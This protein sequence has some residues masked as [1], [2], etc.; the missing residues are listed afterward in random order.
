M[1]PY[2][3]EDPLL[4]FCRANNITVINY[5]PLGVG[6][7]KLLAEPGVLAIAAAHAITPAQALLAW[8]LAYTGG[9]VIPRSSNA[10]H[11]AD[12]LA[13]AGVTLSPAEVASLAGL[14][15]KKMFNV[16]CQPYC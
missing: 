2:W 3:H 4:T 8:G 5:A 6:S 15:Q 14:P 11:M 7:G 9:V 1:H 16:Y 10:T 13:A 12:N